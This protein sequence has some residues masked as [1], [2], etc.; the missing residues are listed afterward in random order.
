MQSWDQSGVTMQGIG[1]I[2]VQTNNLVVHLRTMLNRID[3]TL[4]RNSNT[5][6][7]FHMGCYPHT[8]LVCFIA[9]CRDFFDRHL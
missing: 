7:T 3:A 2:L 6:R 5:F 1:V 4:Q 9:D 8:N